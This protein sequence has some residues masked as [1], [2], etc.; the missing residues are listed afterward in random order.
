MSLTELESGLNWQSMG[1]I[2]G[3]DYGGARTGLAISDETQI[4]G[5][6]LAAWEKRNK[7]S[8]LEHLQVLV[9]DYEVEK[10]VL[11]FPLNLDGSLGKMAQAVLDLKEELG[12]TIGLEIILWVER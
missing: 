1:R 8:L 4:I 3:I 10:M 2:L 11:G 7:N 9:K 6:P 12:K 5:S